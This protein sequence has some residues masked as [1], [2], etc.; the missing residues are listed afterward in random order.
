MSILKRYRNTAKYY[1][2][3][4]REILHMMNIYYLHF[5]FGVYILENTVT[6]YLIQISCFIITT[7]PSREN[8]ISTVQVILS[9]KFI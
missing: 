1:T 3:L 8:I 6:I 5:M 7:F 9:K 4:R 2:T